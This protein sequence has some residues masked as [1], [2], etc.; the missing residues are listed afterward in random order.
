MAVSG[1]LHASAVLPL[2]QNPSARSGACWLGPD[3]R[4]GQKL[5][6]HYVNFVFLFYDS[7][8]NSADHCPVP[9][10]RDSIIW[11]PYNYKPV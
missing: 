7:N 5:S 10:P 2:G 1:S 11:V 8:E 4:V 9:Q 3:T 6:L